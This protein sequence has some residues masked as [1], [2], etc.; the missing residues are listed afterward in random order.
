MSHRCP[1]LGIALPNATVTSNLLTNSLEM[2]FFLPQI[3]SKSPKTQ[4]VFYLQCHNPCEL[5]T[6]GTF[7]TSPFMNSPKMPLITSDPLTNFP[8]MRLLLQISSRPPRRPPKCH[9]LP[10]ISSQAPSKCDFFLP[11]VPQ[12]TIFTSNPLMNSLKMPLFTSDPLT[13]SPKLR[14]FALK[15]SIYTLQTEL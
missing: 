8:R 1:S 3:P 10:Q 4:G 13:N 7:T 6:T 12:N 2:H 14:G 15:R 9:F 11:Q 5:P